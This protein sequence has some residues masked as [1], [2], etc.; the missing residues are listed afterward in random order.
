MDEGEKMGR[1]TEEGHSQRLSV[2]IANWCAQTIYTRG[3]RKQ[4][5][6]RGPGHFEGNVNHCGTKFLCDLRYTELFTTRMKVLCARK[7]N[8]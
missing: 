7:H 3:A 4:Q 5:K 2:L 8:S 1:T 6:H